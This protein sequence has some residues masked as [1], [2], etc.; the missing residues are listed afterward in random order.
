MVRSPLPDLKSASRFDQFLRQALSEI[1]GEEISVHTVSENRDLVSC[2]SQ[3]LAGETGLDSCDI[4][5]WISD[6]LKR[7]WAETGS[8]R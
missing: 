2:I 1:T 8:D 7:Y 6:S 5:R 3:K 4:A